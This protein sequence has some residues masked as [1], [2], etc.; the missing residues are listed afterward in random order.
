MRVALFVCLLVLLGHAGESRSQSSPIGAFNGSILA[1]HNAVRSEVGVPPLVWSESLAE[2]A[3]E[4]ARTLAEE[5]R[6]HHHDRPVYGENL[7]L[8][9]GGRTNPRLVVETWAAEEADYDAKTNSCRA[10]CG[11][12]TQIVWRDTKQVGCGVARS[13]RTEVWVCNYDPPGNYVGER[14][15]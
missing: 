6:L 7:Y 4:W 9:S 8:I 1:A 3:A 12:Y 14:P 13:G 15:Y 5:G 10:R 11:H 2:Y